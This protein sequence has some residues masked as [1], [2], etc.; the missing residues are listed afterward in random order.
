MHTLYDTYIQD[1]AKHLRFS[2]TDHVNGY[3][4]DLSSCHMWSMQIFFSVLQNGLTPYV[5]NQFST[6]MPKQFNNENKV[7]STN[8]E[9]VCKVKKKRKN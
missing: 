3:F 8:W 4:L 5:E 2:N 1:E 7:L 6:K 9:N